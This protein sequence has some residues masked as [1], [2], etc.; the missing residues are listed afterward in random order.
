MIGRTISHYRVLERLG[1]GGMGVVY[2]AEDARLGRLVAIKLLSDDLI[3]DRVAM[4][5]FQR[6][7]RAASALNHPNICTIHE[8]DEADG[9]PFLVMELLE[10]ETLRDVLDRGPL[11]GERLLDVAIEFADALATA[12]EARIIHRD[13]KPANLFLTR[14]GHLKILDFGLAKVMSELND[15][16]DGATQARDLTAAET[17]VGTIAYMSPEQAR[18]EPLD[19]RTDLFSFGAVL[20]ELA[21]GARAFAAPNTA[22]TFDRILHHD[23]PPP[24][25]S[26]APVIMKA[27]QKDREL[28]YQSAAEIRADL[29]RL[30]HEST[31]PTMVTAPAVSRPRRAPALVAIIGA[32]V[33]VV[34]GT[35][36]WR[37]R[38][39]A[40]RAGGPT[41]IAVL[42][43]ENLS[44]KSDRDYLRLALPDELITILSYNRSL[45][46]RPFALSRKFAG[47]ADPQQSGRTLSAANVVTGHFRDAA[48][49][50]DITLEAIDVEKNNVLW[51]D[52]VVVTG[53]DL[54]ALREQLANR[55]RSGLLPMLRAGDD[56]RGPERPKSD[57]AYALVLRAA[58]LSTD[59]GP[60]KEA[61]MMLER[62]VALDP[63][64]APA[65]LALS[66]RAYNDGAYS[67]GGDSATH[68]AEEASMRALE[69][70][71]ELV[72]AARR[73]IVLRVEKGDLAGAYREAK[74]LLRRRPDL[75]DAHFSLSYVYRYAGLL[76]ESTAE[77][78]KARALDPHNV[79]MRSCA[80]AFLAAG[81]A[82]EARDFVA[83]D[84]GSVWARAIE[85]HILL[86][87]GD[88]QGALRQG[89]N[90]G[91]MRL[92]YTLLKAYLEGGAEP[93]LARLSSALKAATLQI[94]DGEPCYYNAVVFAHCRREADALALLRAA[95]ERGYCS[96]PALDTEPAFAHLRGTPELEAAR[97]AANDC[98]ARF[99]SQ[100]GL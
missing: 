45:A 73:L 33:A 10:G 94:R 22:L 93:E 76:P 43:F 21:T 13:L 8:I 88:P 58:A 5:R 24:A 78:R 38:S 36:L 15:A 89:V 37:G 60:N 56:H 52:S 85:G 57:E 79:G 27:L 26:L 84:A 2:K 83:L 66:T 99:R 50:I 31:A 65:W 48:G 68:R 29:R 1:A 9:S 54:I 23:P 47:D 97:K 41:T 40:T 86:R 35:L 64:Y 46:V 30:K 42:P 87:A 7:A 67:I 82:R 44:G 14:L 4:E 11:P 17:T 18:A 59:P 72:E 96:F 32:V 75:A 51:R 98:Q 100:T 70:D 95:V 55:I 25:S 91:P 80:L 49:R 16:S 74:E 69:I 6:E 71:P 3:K 19:A 28:R 34:A 81:D 39:V 20:Y 63:S 61:W 12:H 53:D 77:C 92:W 62:A 90:E